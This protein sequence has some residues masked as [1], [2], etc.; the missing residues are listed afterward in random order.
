MD[1]TKLSLSEER[2]LI[3]FQLPGISKQGRF[4]EVSESR[5]VLT[6]YVLP[7][8]YLQRQYIPIHRPHPHPPS[9][10]HPVP[11]PQPAP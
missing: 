11:H 1:S 5:Y 9:R 2:H 10:P 4:D 7:R 6:M 3:Q 8:L